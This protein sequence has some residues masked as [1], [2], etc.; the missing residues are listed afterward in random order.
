M[1]EL[2]K[3]PKNWYLT[4]LNEEVDRANEAVKNGNDLIDPKFTGHWYAIKRLM[5]DKDKE[6]GYFGAQMILENWFI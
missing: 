4:V 3:L 2:K 6:N 5:L 1:T